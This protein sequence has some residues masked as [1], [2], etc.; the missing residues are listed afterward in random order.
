MQLLYLQL[1]I[2]NLGNNRFVDIPEA[3]KFC[4]SLTKLH[5]FGNNVQTLSPKTLGK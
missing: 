2:V 4:S 5:M 3:L 1:E